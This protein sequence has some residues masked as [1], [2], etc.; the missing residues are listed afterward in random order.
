TRID[1]AD[2][3]DDYDQ[4]EYPDG[5]DPDDIAEYEAERRL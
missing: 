2:V 1:N 3:D 5:H 4:A